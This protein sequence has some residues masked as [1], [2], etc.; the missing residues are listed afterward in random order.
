MN[1]EKLHHEATFSAEPGT[2]KVKILQLQ[3][4]SVKCYFP[5][6][7]QWS[8]QQ[9]RTNGLRFYQLSSTCHGIPVSESQTW[10]TTGKERSH[11]P[12][13]HYCSQIY[14]GIFITIIYNT[15]VITYIF[16]PFININ[17]LSQK[18]YSNNMF[19]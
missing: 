18:G 17:I 11:L 1:S 13:T 6:N 2:S 4:L 19:T 14:F 5:C 8:C 3:L 12:P 15:P 9:H 16:Q 10:G 7:D